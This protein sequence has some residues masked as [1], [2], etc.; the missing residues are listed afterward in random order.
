MDEYMNEEND[1]RLI[2]TGES[3]SQKR[4]WIPLAIICF[5]LLLIV[6][7]LTGLRLNRSSCN[8]ETTERFNET[9]NRLLTEE[10]DRLKQTLLNIDNHTSEGWLYFRRSLYLGSSTKRTWQESRLYCQERGADLLI[11]NTEQE[12]DFARLTFSERRW[13]GLREPDQEK[14]WKW[15]DSS[16]VTISFWHTGEPS[17]FGDYEDCVELNYYTDGTRNWNDDNCVSKHKCICEKRFTF[18]V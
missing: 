3:A 4:K 2:P 6:S 10:R 16:L 13:I 5:G 12:Q 14:V 9:R 15:V 11:I 1:F 8:N 17:N 18:E 7:L